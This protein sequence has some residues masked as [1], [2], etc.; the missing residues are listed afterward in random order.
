MI[1]QRSKPL[2]LMVVMFGCNLF[3]GFSRGYECGDNL[4]GRVL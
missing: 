3:D 4:V 2:V 1:T